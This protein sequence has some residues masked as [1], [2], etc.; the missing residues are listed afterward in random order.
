MGK[1]ES[2]R[3]KTVNFVLGED[4][5]SSRRRELLYGTSGIL[6]LIIQFPPLIGISAF[7]FTGSVHR[8]LVSEAKRESKL[9][10]KEK[11]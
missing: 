8:N 5:S 3:E 10:E 9:I 11:V 7:F 2:L 4:T 6:G 1:N